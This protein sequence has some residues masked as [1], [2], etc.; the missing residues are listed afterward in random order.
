MFEENES[1]RPGI[2][3]NKQA[4]LLWGLVVLVA[5]PGGYFYWRHWNL[6]QARANLAAINGALS[7]YFEQFQ[8]YPDTLER[9]RG[10]GSEKESGGPPERA[11]LLPAYLAHD[12]FGAGGYRYKYRARR[13]VLRWAATV[14][15]YLE[16]ELTAEPANFLTAWRH[17]ATD[18]SG[19]VLEAGSAEALAEKVMSRKQE[20]DENEVAEAADAAEEE[21]GEDKSG[22][23]VIATPADE[24]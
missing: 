18:F 12:G 14:P 2:R 7:V 15:L 10:L 17:L 20:D 19:E 16:Y 5:L 3:W 4:L 13:R 22:V 8:G 23:E 24:E 11:R 6:S 9:L 1:A 21:G